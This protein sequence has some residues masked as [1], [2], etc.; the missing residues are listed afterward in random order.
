MLREGFRLCDAV[1]HQ[2]ETD[3][4]LFA[5]LLTTAA[6]HAKES[7]T[8]IVDA[9]TLWKRC[10]FTRMEQ[11]LR[12]SLYARRAKS[13]FALHK[14]NVRHFSVTKAYDVG[15]AGSNALT[16]AITTL[17]SAPPGQSDAISRRYALPGKEFT[18][19]QR[20]RF[21]LIGEREMV[22]KIT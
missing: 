5:T 22:R 16:A 11:R 6:I 18:S 19:R 8:A 12:A 9:N 17:F 2:V 13:A 1:G 14:I 3:G 10:R 15:F 21:T 20:H 7:D 4:L